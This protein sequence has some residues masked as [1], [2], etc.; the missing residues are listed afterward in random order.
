MRASQRRRGGWG[1]EFDRPN[2]SA[3]GTGPAQRTEGRMEGGHRMEARPNTAADM[4]KWP[5]LPMA[6]KEV[7]HIA[8]STKGTSVGPYPGQ[9]GLAGRQGW[10]NGERSAGTG[11]VRRPL[12]TPRWWW[13]EAEEA[14]GIHRARPQTIFCGPGYARPSDSHIHIQARD[15]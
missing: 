10:I 6:G 13:A 5:E 7:V 11:G 8:N 2:P 1:E 4:L 3:E 15:K 14:A 12:P 9:W